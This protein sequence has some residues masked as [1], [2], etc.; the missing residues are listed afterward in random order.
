MVPM[1]DPHLVIISMGLHAPLVEGMTAGR[2][3]HNGVL[4]MDASVSTQHAVFHEVGEGW[5]VKDPNSTN[6]TW[7]DGI[8]MQSMAPLVDSGS[9]RPRVVELRLEGLPAPQPKGVVAAPHP[10]PAPIQRPPL[11]PPLPGFSSGILFART[12]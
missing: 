3:S 1:P 2:G 12:R 11:P 5:M 8:R 7:I 10:L 9:L 6:G 4:L